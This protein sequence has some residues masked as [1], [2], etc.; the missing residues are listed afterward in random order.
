MARK[1]VETEYRTT[2]AKDGSF[3]VK[4]DKD[5]ADRIRRYC[6]LTNQCKTKFV[7][8]CVKDRLHDCEQ[9]IAEQILREKSKEELVQMIMKGLKGR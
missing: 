4:I 6:E 5:V 7:V 3:S 2:C 1:R 8:Q 9:E